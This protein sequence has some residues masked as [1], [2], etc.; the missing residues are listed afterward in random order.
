MGFSK[1]YGPLVISESAGKV[2]LSINESESVG[3]GS[4][5]GVVSA[6]GSASVIIDGAVL[7]DAGLAYLAAK[8]PQLKVEIALVQG[9]VDAELQKL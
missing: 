5:K 9:E 1:N 3:G 6:Q 2:S 4:V 8:F 7:A